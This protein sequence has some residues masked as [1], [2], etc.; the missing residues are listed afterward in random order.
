MKL[1]KAFLIAAAVVGV[2]AVFNFLSQDPEDFRRQT[3]GWFP[4]KTTTT[5]D[6]SKK[7]EAPKAPEKVVVVIHE[8]ELVTPPPAPEKVVI[9]VPEKVIVVHDRVN[10][11]KPPKPISYYYHYHS[12]YRTSYFNGRTQKTTTI[13]ESKTEYSSRSG[14]GYNFD[15]SK[16]TTWR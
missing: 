15:Y 6:D 10:P 7:P 1:K 12:D 3:S 11:P 13:H 16:R 8:K 9:V 14:F 4:K 5:Y 2:G